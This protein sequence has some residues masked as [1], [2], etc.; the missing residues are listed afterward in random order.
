[1]GDAAYDRRA[2]DASRQQ[3]GDGHIASKTKP[4][5][6]DKNGAQL[7]GRDLRTLGLLSFL[8]RME[9]K[10]V[11]SWPLLVAAT[12]V[13]DLVRGG[14]KFLD[15]RKERM[16]GAVHEASGEVRNRDFRIYREPRTAC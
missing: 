10:P 9:P 2:V 13:E 1:M 3:H 15:T 6:I 11:R 12:Q 14:R 16:L 7:L 8:E 5:R 4:Y